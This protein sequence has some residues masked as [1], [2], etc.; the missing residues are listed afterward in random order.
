MATFKVEALKLS[1][2]YPHPNADRLELGQ[3]E[4][5][6]FQFVI[7]KDVYKVGET[8]IYFPVDSLLSQDFVQQQNIANHLAGKDKNRVKTCTL[9]KEISQGYVTSVKSVLEHL[10]TD[11]IPEDLTSVLNV[12][13]YEPPEVMTHTGRLVRLPEHVYYYD[14]EGCDRYPNILALLLDRK[15]VITEKLEGSN[16]GTSIN[17]GGKVSVNQHA[18]AIE[19]IPDKEEHTFWKIA[20]QEGIIDMVTTL[21]NLFPNQTITIRGEAL[22]PKIQSNYYNLSKYVV[23][24]YDLEFDGH[25]VDYPKLPDILVKANI[26]ENWKRLF[27]PVI[28]ENIVLKEWLGDKTIQQASN[29]KSALIDKLREGIVIKPMIEEF[30]HGFGR[31]FLKQRDPIYLDKTGN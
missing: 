4:G 2:I 15:V 20:R 3:V 31:L 30:I 7:P 14:I 17:P 5:M 27:V 10:K 16:F 21:H 23:K 28:A 6:L 18:Y 19:N 29:G 25:A 26:L 22:G 13:K 11:T 12:V 1:K 24:V 9:R 8:I